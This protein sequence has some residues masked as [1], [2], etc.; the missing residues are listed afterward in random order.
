[1]AEGVTNNSSAAALK[2]CSRA[3]TWKVFKNLSDGKRM[4]TYDTSSIQSNIRAN[5]KNG[6]ICGEAAS[7][8]FRSAL[9]ASG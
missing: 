7:R 1:M 3:A 2:L 4:Q 9:F 6:L 5:A 8:R